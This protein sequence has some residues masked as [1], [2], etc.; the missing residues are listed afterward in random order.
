MRITRFLSFAFF[1]FLFVHAQAQTVAINQTGKAADHSA[2]LDVQS[3]S[4]GLLLPR[5]TAAQRGAIP[6]PAKGLLV[7]QI[8]GKEGLY[9]NAGTAAAPVWSRMDT[10]SKVAFSA[11]SSLTQSITSFFAKLQFPVEEYDES[12]SFVPGFASEFTVP[13]DGVYHFDATVICQGSSGVRYDLALFVNGVQKKTVVLIPSS[14]LLS[15]HL[16]ADMKLATGDK[17]DARIYGQN[18]GQIVGSSSP[19]VWFNGHK[20]N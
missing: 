1:C 12:S 11:T 19:W 8:D 13:S 16:S 6:E 2:M 20:I 18:G 10:V 14:T 7:Y 9:L 17:V 3:D 15:L 5:M 4:K